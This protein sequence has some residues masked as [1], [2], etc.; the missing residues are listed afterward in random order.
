MGAGRHLLHLITDLCHSHW[1]L[2]LESK[3]RVWLGRVF[4]AWHS[5]VCLIALL[6]VW[7]VFSEAQPSLD[8][9]FP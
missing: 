4:E 6:C 1:V 5:Y 9:W 7:C 8:K 2:V 3:L